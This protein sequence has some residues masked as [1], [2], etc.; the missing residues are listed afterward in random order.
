MIIITVL[1][2]ILV[3][4]VANSITAVKKKKKDAA[5]TEKTEESADKPAQDTTKAAPVPVPAEDAGIP[6]SRK[7]T[8]AQLEKEDLEEQKKIAEGEW[9]KDPFFHDDM[10][11]Q[12]G[13]APGETPGEDVSPEKL[14]FGLPDT[15]ETIRSS[16][17]LTGISLINDTYIAVINRKMVKV[18]D[19]I[20]NDR[21]KFN[22][23]NITKDKV[24]LEADGGEYELK[25]QK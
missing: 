20:S 13:Q 23:K 12:Q 14:S 25:L 9:D 6:L 19:S 24:I 7:P 17:Q 1:L 2:L 3:Y 11:S 16:F 5:A 8:K 10:S 22:I 4:A 15:R 18:G 21:F